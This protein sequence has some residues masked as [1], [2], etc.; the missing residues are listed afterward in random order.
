MEEHG[1]P[2]LR[3]IVLFLIASGII[4]PI[5][6]RLRVSPVLGYL[7]IGGIIG[8]FGLGMFVEDIGWLSYA[9]I[10][11]LKGVSALAELGVIFLLF[12]IGL[13]LSLD[14]LWAMRRWV[15]GLGSLQILITGTIIGAI[16]WG[17]GNTPAASIVLGSCL[18]LSST[19]I[20]MQLL[21]ERRQLASPMGRS[22]FSILL[23]QDLAVVP[24][25]FMVGVLGSKAQDGVGMALLLSLGKAVLVIV[26][27]YVLG[28]L[29]IRPL[30]HMVAR[31]RSVEMFMAATLL[32]V[33]GASAV[34]GMA[35]LSMAL[36]AFLAG[37]LLAETEFRHEIEVDIEPFKGLL[38][39]LFFMSVGMGIDYRVVGEQT[40]WIIASVVGLFT[41]K[42]AITASLCLVFGL[43]RHTS[44]ETGLLLGQGGEFAFVVVGLAMT[45][46][47]IPGE[48]GQFMLIVTGISMVITPLVASASSH[49]IKRLEPSSTT[50]SHEGNIEQIGGME[51][52]VVVAGFGRVG[53]ILGRTLD[54]DA[55]PYVAIDT[56]PNS[57]AAVR[58]QGMPVYYGDASRLEMLRRAH[59]DKASALVVTMDNAAAAEHVVKVVHAEWPH[60][61]IVARARDAAHASRLLD[62]GAAEV[63]ME[64]I[65]ASLQLSGRIL[66]LVGTPEEVSHRRIDAQREQELAA[67]RR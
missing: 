15:F 11:D 44:L 8:P 56:D 51:G 53:R 23:M 41:L 21:I 16:A 14:R 45:L 46:G 6:H 1:I 58:E 57:V 59:L 55:I 17:F 29:V 25:L 18:A 66:Q 4:V 19:A 61:A 26:G 31:T 3:E 33:I 60:L 37:L 20:V 62:C 52:H 36:G 67:V 42:T 9:V 22:S 32:M 39:G 7:I 54:A 38:L 30:F 27:I 28:R 48:V 63:I 65:E 40:F 12:M 24:I 64:T 49:L 35:G 13:D 2:Y 34:T 50:A 47:L 10:S 5:L 43:P